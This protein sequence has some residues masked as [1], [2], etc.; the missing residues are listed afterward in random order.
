MDT[1]TKCFANVT[2]HKEPRMVAWT[3]PHDNY[4]KLDVDGSSLGNPGRS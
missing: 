3:P 2:I 1:C 4:V